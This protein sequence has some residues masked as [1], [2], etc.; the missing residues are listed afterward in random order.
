MD[1]GSSPVERS[2]P[3]SKRA[4]L[5][6]AFLL[7]VILLIQL[8]V[9]LCLSSFEF[10]FPYALI[11]ML[12]GLFV[13]PSVLIVL[14]IAAFNISRHK[15][16]LFLAAC[17]LLLFLDSAN[18]FPW[19]PETANNE[20]LRAIRH[21]FI[22]IIASATLLTPL[23]VGVF[24]WKKPGARAYRISRCSLLIFVFI[25]LSIGS[26]ISGN[27]IAKYRA[28]RYASEVKDA[29]LPLIESI[30]KYEQEFGQYPKD[31]DEVFSVHNTGRDVV[32]NNDVCYWSDSNSFRIEF[33]N[34]VGRVKYWV[35]DSNSGKWSLY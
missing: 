4:R 28:N 24:L 15:G 12:I 31:L 17:N 20:W 9:I 18:F 27:S 29:L 10:N 13:L 8:P 23:L 16:Y 7:S 1:K 30:N 5:V 21:G 11:M 25:I 3:G 34:P 22:I 33:P 14:S 19:P 6:T 35:Y 26:F 2:S 32:Y